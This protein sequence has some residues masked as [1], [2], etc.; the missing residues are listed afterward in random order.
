MLGKE[1]DDLSFKEL[2][3]LEEQLSEGILSVK[4]KKVLS[5]ILSLIWS[6]KFIKSG[7]FNYLINILTFFLMCGFELSLNK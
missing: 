3:H 1:L 2:Q 5:F 7:E 4:D 6:H